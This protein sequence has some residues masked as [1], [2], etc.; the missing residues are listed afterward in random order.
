[1]RLILSYV[2]L[3]PYSLEKC[4]GEIRLRHNTIMKNM[5]FTAKLRFAAK[6]NMSRYPGGV[7]FASQHHN[8]K[9]KIGG[10]TYYVDGTPESMFVYLSSETE[11]VFFATSLFGD[12]T[13]F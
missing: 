7:V 5:G 3:S 11:P 13:V 2:I 6:D 1:M 8:V 12:W 10:K 4:N 9:V